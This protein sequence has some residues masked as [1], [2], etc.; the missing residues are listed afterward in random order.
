MVMERMA[1]IVKSYIYEGLEKLE[2]PVLLVKQYMRDMQEEMRSL[3][4]IIEKHHR[5]DRVLAK[6][7]QSAEELANRREQQAKAAL[8]AEEEDLARKALVSKKEAIEQMARYEQLRER[9]KVQLNE[10]RQ[11]LEQMKTKYKHLYDRKLELT[12]RVQAVRANAQIE[13]LQQKNRVDSHLDFEFARME[14]RIGEL[15]WKDGEL[16][17]NNARREEEQYSE[18]IQAELDRLKR[19]DEVS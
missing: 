19:K 2:D 13:Q 16:N 7:W 3:E 5:L 9:N 1:A 12:L 17:K 10:S 15:E 18:D 6:D 11:R 14:E 4:S 8:E